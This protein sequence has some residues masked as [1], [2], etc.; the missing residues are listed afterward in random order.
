MHFRNQKTARELSWVRTLS[1]QV[2]PLRMPHKATHAR[3]QEHF[4]HVMS[5]M[6]QAFLCNQ[7][8]HL[9]QETHLDQQM[10]FIEIAR[11]V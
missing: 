9:K 1:N 7:Q 3:V 6:Y 4:M 8:T 5:C 11:K 10:H 2:K